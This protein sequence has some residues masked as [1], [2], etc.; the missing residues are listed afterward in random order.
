MSAAT[1]MPRPNPARP[2]GTQT[3]AALS[4]T[5]AQ[6]STT[7][8]GGHTGAETVGTGSSD[9]ARLVCSLH[10]IAPY[11][12]IKKPAHPCAH[13][14]RAC[15]QTGKKPRTRTIHTKAPCVKPGCH[16]LY[17]YCKG[18]GVLGMAGGRGTGTAGTAAAAGDKGGIADTAGAGNGGKAAA[19]CTGGLTGAA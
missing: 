19:C 8:G 7:T 14:R 5:A 11:T 9:L 6:H 18:V 17:P 3:L 2:S 4:A 12:I 10:D 16:C 1:Q 15:E 13:E